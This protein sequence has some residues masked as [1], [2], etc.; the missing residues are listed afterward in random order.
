MH[1][2]GRFAALALV[3]FAVACSSSSAG[4][5]AVDAGTSVD[6]G[7]V[8]TGGAL[9]VA[10]AAP[11][12]GVDVGPTE[13]VY[14]PYMVVS[15]AEHEPI[16]GYRLIRGQIHAHT[17]YSHDGCDEKLGEE[18]ILDQDCLTD[19]RNAAC[20]TA[21]DFVCITDH[22]DFFA[23]YEFPEVLLYR[24]DEGDELI[25]RDGDPVAN[26]VACPEGGE[27][28]FLAGTDNHLLAIGLERHAGETPDERYAV[29]GAKTIEAVETLRVN[30][31]LTASG[32]SDEWDV[33]LLYSLPFDGF[34]VYNPVTNLRT[35]MAATAEMVAKML[36]A[37]EDVPVPEIGIISIYQENEESLKRWAHLLQLRPVFSYIGTNAHQNVFK[38]PT[39][40]GERLDSWRRLF[41]WYANYVLVPTDEELTDR[42]LIDAIAAGRIYGIAEFLGYPA[43]W[44]CYLTVGEEAHEMGARVDYRIVPHH[45]RDW[46]GTDPDS[47]IFEHLWMYANPIFIGVDYDAE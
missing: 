12:T 38:D 9:D 21:M 7:V 32:Y 40:D 5:P 4:D 15:A 11:D 41:H 34:E 10:T 14:D 33:D 20:D 24:E 13:P 29:Y 42:V 27:S 6:V 3:L 8:D 25:M 35:N 31:A 26:R 45:L 22:D 18:G 28:L 23:E 47:L 37:P 1:R 44:D 17:S 46:L 43:D 36:T 30:G 2:F 19:F 39:S 16:R